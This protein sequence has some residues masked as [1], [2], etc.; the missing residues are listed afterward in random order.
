MELQGKLQQSTDGKEKDDDVLLK[1]L[2]GSDSQRYVWYK[3][4]N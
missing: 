2:F 4:N 3:I 1:S